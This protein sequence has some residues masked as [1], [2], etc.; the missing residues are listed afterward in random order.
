MLEQQINKI[1]GC[2]EYANFLLCRMEVLYIND[3][4]RYELFKQSLKDE[5]QLWKRK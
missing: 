5:F 1:V 3:Q 4:P 2:H